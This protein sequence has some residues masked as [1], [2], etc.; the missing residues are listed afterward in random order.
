MNFHEAPPLRIQLISMPYVPAG[1]SL[2]GVPSQIEIDNVVSLLGRMYPT[3][4]VLATQATMPTQ[5]PPETC[6]QARGRV[7]DFAGAVAAL[8]RRVRFYGLLEEIGGGLEITDGDGNRISGCM[9]LP[10][11]F[12]WGKIALTRA[13]FVLAGHELGH[14]FGRRHVAGCPLF[15]GSSTDDGYPHAGGLIGDPILG[16]ALGYDAGDATLGVDDQLLDWRKGV[17]DVMTYCDSKWISDHTYRFIL[18]RLC[19]EDPAACPDHDLLAGRARSGG[20]TAR[21]VKRAPGKPRLSVSGRIGTG[22]ARLD[23][24]AVRRGL[25]LSPRPRKG[26]YAVV[27]ADARGRRVGRYRFAP[28]EVSEGAGRTIDAVVPFKPATRLITVVEG[29]R[30]LAAER[31]S[32]HAPSVEVVAPKRAPKGKQRVRVRWRSRDAD[33][34]R[35]TYTLLYAPKGKRLVPV[36]AGLRKRS[37]RVDLSRLPGGRRARFVVIANDGVLTGTDASKPIRVAAKPPQVS[38][39]APA[40]GAELSSEGPVQLVAT[41]RDLQDPRFDGADVVWRSSLQG[42]LGRGTVLAAT[43]AAGDHAITATATNSAGQSSSATISVRV[44][45]PA[46]VFTVP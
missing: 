40:G 3:N 31:V 34:G 41:V 30:R 24:L 2:P 35:R 28:Q 37:Y 43:L 25:E 45:A 9:N 6:A 38:I 20:G 29:G 11:Q 33:G 12:G 27:L 8:D 26:S 15:E 39:T 32:A 5:R 21:S 16:D 22:E 23:S 10:G 13:R 4:M 42:E 36:A 46:P 14:S 44:S 1:G 17:A 7:R 19:D 18:G